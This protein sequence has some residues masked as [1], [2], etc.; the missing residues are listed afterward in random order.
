MSRIV[1]LA[2]GWVVALCIISLPANSQILAKNK[3]LSPGSLTPA[4][5]LPVKEAYQPEAW[6]EGDDLIIRWNI[7][8]EHYLYRDRTFFSGQGLQ[9][10]G[11]I[12]AEGLLVQDEFYQKE[13]VVYRGSTE[14][15]LRRLGGDGVL[16]IEAQ[17]CA[18]AG[19]C[20][21]ATD[22]WFE[23]DG[24]SR[25]VV[26]SEEM[27]LSLKGA[28]PAP[29]GTIKSAPRIANLLAAL[30]LAFAGGLILNLMPCVFPILAIKA[31]TISSAPESPG[32]RL[33]EAGA[34][35][36][37]I[38]TTVLIIAGI[39][40]A[41]RA[42]GAQVGWG[43]Q[44]QSPPVILTLTILFFVIGLS[45]SGWIE[46]GARFAGIG[47]SLTGEGRPLK[48][49]FTGV[50]AMIVASPC[51][52][53][54]MAAALGYA[55]SQPAGISLL[56]FAGLGL[57]VAAPL[58]LLYLVPGFAALLPKPGAWME[59]LKQFL[60][61]PMYLTCIWLIWVLIAQV[62][63][64]GAAFAMASLCLL[65]MTIWLYGKY[66]DER[67]RNDSSRSKKSRGYLTGITACISFGAAVFLAL[68]S[69]QQTAP[70]PSGTAFSLSDL[71]RRTGGSQPVFL[72]VT[73]DWCITCKFNESRVL[74]SP[75]IQAL[76]EQQGV[77]YLVADW[78]NENPE[79]TR[80][81]HRYQRAGI[82]LYLY[83][84][85]GESSPIILPQILTKKMLRNLFI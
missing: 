63:A 64:T 51:S 84:A 31:L 50:L 5:F 12:F 9:H 11:A 20:Y 6:F 74:Y 66:S 32:L 23:I 33:K 62:G 60:A 54:F 70:K 71:D 17:G 14:M 85:P 83:F 57:G 43:F 42:G 22:F 18:D 15:Q 61:F 27:P 65:T 40:I 26:Y 44:L 13:M 58:I 72:D 1:L 79:I 19:L 3:S 76:F 67:F 10:E 24:E 37:G 25:G 38:L 21:P 80:L 36:A 82:P 59:T 52:A 75:D 4:E 41:V 2:A 69:L 56:V 28:S 16:T 7:A 68:G 48:S 46:F 30:I 45:F 8:P 73:A 39:L 29:A 78:T 53:P 49:F 35:T 81:L 34:Y 47:Q 77:F 55:I